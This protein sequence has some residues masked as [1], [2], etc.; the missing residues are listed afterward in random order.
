MLS[1]QNL[2]RFFNLQPYSAEM[3]EIHGRVLLFDLHGVWIE[4]NPAVPLLLAAVDLGT[5]I[6]SRRWLRATAPFQPNYDAGVFTGCGPRAGNREIERRQM[7]DAE[8]FIAL[9][10]ARWIASAAPRGALDDCDF[11]H[12]AT[13][14]SPAVRRGFANSR[15]DRDLYRAVPRFAGFRFRLLTRSPPERKPRKCVVEIF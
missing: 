3:T 7:R 4:A 9:P 5:R 8:E 1:D 2:S 13:C 11:L 12:A 10:G 6:G 14:R 15:V